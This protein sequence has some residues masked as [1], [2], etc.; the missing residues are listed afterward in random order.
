MSQSADHQAALM[1]GDGGADVLAV[2]ISAA[3]LAARAEGLP[4]QAAHR[5]AQAVCD[6]LRREFGALR[7]YVPAPDRSA[8]DRAILTGLA[9][10]ESRG[11]I[12]HRVGVHPTTVDRV[13]RRHQ[14]RRHQGDGLG[15]A[16]WGL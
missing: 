1:S 10:G 5:L 4:V 2:I 13:A 7:V 15:P 14:A 3:T 8:R 12:A 6:R 11:D 16:G 9:A